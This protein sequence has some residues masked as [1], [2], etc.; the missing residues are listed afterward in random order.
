MGEHTGIGCFTIVQVKDG[1]GS[2]AGWGR[3]K[4][5]FGWIALDLCEKI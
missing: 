1:A 4:S 5:G 2:D 3:L